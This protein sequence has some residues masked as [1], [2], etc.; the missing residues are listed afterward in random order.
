MKLA[1]YP[2]GKYTGSAVVKVVGSTGDPTEKD[3]AVVNSTLQGLGFKT[4]FTL[5]DQSVMYSKYCAVP[6]RNIGVC[7]N[8][9]WVRDFADPQT[10][11]DPAFSGSNI[12]P[13]NN[14]NWGQ[15]DDPQVNA[16][17]AAAER[18]TGESA[19]AEAWARVDTLLVDKAVAIP[20]I[21]DKGPEI[22]SKDVRGVIDLWNGGTCDYAYSS[23]K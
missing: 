18:V 7:P 4:N 22:E 8:V 9:G 5:V 11:I 1:G 13:T 19:R 3:A 12:T 17:I 15:V 14:S 2:G 6:A 23:S 20:W 21:F 16:A 10:I